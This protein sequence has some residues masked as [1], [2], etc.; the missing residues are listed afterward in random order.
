[1]I[2]DVWGPNWAGYNR[3][4]PLSAN[5]KRR[6]NRISQLEA[7]QSRH[8]ARQISKRREWEG[9]RRK[10]SWRRLIFA[11]GSEKQDGDEEEV[12]EEEEWE[13]PEWALKEDEEDECGDVGFDIVWTISYVSLHSEAL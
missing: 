5:V 7:S 9:R 10:R 2:T 3:S 1:V 13:R 6:A 8:A 4:I 12:F 11:P